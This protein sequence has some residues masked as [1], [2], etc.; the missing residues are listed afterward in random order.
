MVRY[1]CRVLAE[2]LNEELSQRVEKTGERGIRWD[3]KGELFEE[4]ENVCCCG[5]RCEVG[6]C[7]ARCAL[8]CWD[9][10]EL[11]EGRGEINA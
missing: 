5:R 7:D 6:Q 2:R 11:G 9:E 4:S 10:G 3:V 8:D 1:E